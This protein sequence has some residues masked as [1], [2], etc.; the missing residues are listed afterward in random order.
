M[1]MAETSLKAYIEKKPELEGDRQKI[2][3]TIQ[4]YGPITLEEVADRLGKYPHTISGR[5]TELRDNN[6]IEVTGKTENQAGNTVRR[7]DIK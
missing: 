6:L 7:Y 2:F 4:T 3:E 5:F 1:A